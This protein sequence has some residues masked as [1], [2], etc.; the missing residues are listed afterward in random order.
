MAKPLLIYANV[1]FCNSKCHFCDWVVQVPT[2]QLRLTSESPARVR[3]LDAIRAQIRSH[4]PAL[5]ADGY[6]P[7][8]MYWGGGTASI[9]GAAEI[10]K[11]HAGLAGEF[12][13]A[14]LSEATIEGSPESLDLDKLTLLR[15]LGFNR[16][17]IGVQSFDDV[18]LRKI[19]RSHSAE[20]ALASLDAAR[21]AGFRNVN[22]DLI[23]GFPDQP[24]EE[25][26]RTIRQAVSLPVNHFSIYPYRASPGTVL[27]KQVNRGSA[28]LNVRRQLEAY[29][30]AQRILESSGFGEYAMS[31]FG[32]PRCRSDEAYYRLQM[33]WI[34]FGSGA[35]SLINQ[36]Y[37]A[38][39]RGNLQRFNADPAQFDVNAPAA[40]PALTM[41]F[42]A[43]AL[44][45]AEGMDA[46]LFQE[47]TGVP[48]RTACA[49]PEVFAYLKKM[50]RYGELIVDR[51]G[52]RLRRADLA[53]TYV[54]LSWIDLPSPATELVLEQP[55]TG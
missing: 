30:L 34:G 4:A 2:A 18:R 43:Q 51:N 25:V 7:R 53:P 37:L 54:A 49:D 21:A 31:Y 41:H 38:T 22:I 1:P 36:R 27:R 17:S 52:I 5:N 40:S 39:N 26:E 10:E 8:I 28:E 45:T 12:D 29:R 35:N 46:R 19:G 3:Y 6:R 14:A 9:L 33:D 32:A 13:L 16:V 23:V 44:T 15:Q 47:R 50:G 42:L 20:Q 48:L 55:R 24:L 11:L